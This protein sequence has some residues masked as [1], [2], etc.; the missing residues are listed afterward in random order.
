MPDHAN[1]AGMTRFAEKL[2]RLLESRDLTQARAA[3]A[4][5]VE[6]TALGRWLKD[7]SGRKPTPE[8]VCRLA[9][10]L[11]V[12]MEYLVDDSLDEPHRP[13]VTTDELYVVKAVRALRL[14]FEA[15]LRLLWEHAPRKTLAPAEGSG[16]RVERPPFRD[17]TEGEGTAE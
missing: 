1:I 7:G 11:D 10:F 13:E 16:P 4:A 14:D 12:P 17:R 9:R 5:G 15:T 8:Q 3:R 2:T 6:P